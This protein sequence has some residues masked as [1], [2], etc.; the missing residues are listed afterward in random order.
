MLKNIWKHSIIRFYIL[1]AI[2]NY[3]FWLFSKKSFKQVT[4]QVDDGDYEMDFDFKLVKPKKK[5]FVKRRFVGYFYKN[6]IYLDNPGF[7]ID[8]R[9]TWKAWKKKGLIK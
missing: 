6:N 4:Y 2:W 9:D 8:D 1:N 7:K 3:K 5:M